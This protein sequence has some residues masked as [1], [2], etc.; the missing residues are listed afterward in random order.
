MNFVTVLRFSDSL[1]AFGNDTMQLPVRRD[2][3]GCFKLKNMI[4]EL[5]R[6]IDEL[7]V[8]QNHIR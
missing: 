6:L 2:D 5:F 3:I 8:C 1:K 4:R 7:L